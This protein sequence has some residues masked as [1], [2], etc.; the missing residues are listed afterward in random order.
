MTELGERVE[1][2]DWDFPDAN[3]DAKWWNNQLTKLIDEL[4]GLADEST[5]LLGSGIEPDH[6]WGMG[7]GSMLLFYFQM[8]PFT[9]PLLIKT[10][11][12]CV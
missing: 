8:T 7:R 1:K 2:R 11:K 9:W 3:G 12:Q 6:G 10:L 5:G 4:E